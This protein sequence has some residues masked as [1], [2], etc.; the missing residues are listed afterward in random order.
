MKLGNKGHFIFTCSWAPCEPMP[1]K[2]GL[3][4]C[5]KAVVLSNLDGCHSAKVRQS[6]EPQPGR[7][8]S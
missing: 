6:W 2:T 8:V 4:A 7:V 1:F 5:V 3:V